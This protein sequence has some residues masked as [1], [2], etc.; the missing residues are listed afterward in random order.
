MSILGPTGG[1]EHSNINLQ[2][3]TLCAEIIHADIRTTDAPLALEAQS[4]VQDAPVVE[5]HRLTWLQLDGEQE[6]RLR[7]DLRPCPC[8]RV[9][10]LQ[11]RVVRKHG[12]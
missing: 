10:F 8:G 6:L 1:R 2:T 5:N 4:S 12:R 3:A 7:E 11:R 9:P